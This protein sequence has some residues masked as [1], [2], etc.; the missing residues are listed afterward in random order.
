MIS[1]DELNAGKC[2]RFRARASAPARRN[3]FDDE[4]EHHPAWRMVLVQD[5]EAKICNVKK[6]NPGSLG[7]SL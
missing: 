7:P 4:H 5:R 1:F 6:P 3:P 2:G